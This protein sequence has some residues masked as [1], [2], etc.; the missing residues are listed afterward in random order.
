M[1]R[2]LTEPADRKSASLE[3]LQTIALAANDAS[4][5]GEAVEICLDGVDPL[6]WRVFL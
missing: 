3:L 4:T 2:D 6:S 5:V 1:K